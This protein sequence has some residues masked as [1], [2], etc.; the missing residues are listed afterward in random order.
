MSRRNRAVFCQKCEDL[1]KSVCIRIG[2]GVN[3][4]D[5]LKRLQ[6]MEIQRGS[7]KRGGVVHLRFE[8][9]VKEALGMNE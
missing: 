6:A 2:V 1:A 9:D 3:I 5:N 4:H 7:D 8:E